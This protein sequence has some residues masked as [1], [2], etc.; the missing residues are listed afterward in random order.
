MD[1]ALAAPDVGNRAAEFTLS[2]SVEMASVGTWRDSVH[3]AAR[4]VTSVTG[5]PGSGAAGA[6]CAVGSP[7]R[8]GVSRRKD[9][10]WWALGGSLCISRPTAGVSPSEKM[11]GNGLC[12]IPPSSLWDIGLFTHRPFHP[13]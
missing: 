6:A 8:S 5:C 9:V 2:S 7:Q 11:P 4:T 3:G 10:K 12:L 1:S 13:L